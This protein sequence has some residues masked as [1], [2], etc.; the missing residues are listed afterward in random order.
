M[1][2][3]ANEED[4]ELDSSMMVPKPVGML[5]SPTTRIAAKFVDILFL[6]VLGRLLPVL[7]AAVLGVLYI[8]L[9]DGFQR[10]TWRSQSLGKKLFGI[11][12][13]SRISQEPAGFRESMI[14]NSPFGFAV[15]FGMI[16]IWGWI[17]LIFIGIPLI[18]IEIFLLF[19]VETR[20]RLG[21]VMADTEIRF[22]NQE[23]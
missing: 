8:M 2:D 14:R 10:G 12:V 22:V 7:L 3:G 21:D 11:R 17:L 9:A 23:E 16:A 18:L 6:F 13:Y 5:P 4:I 19:R 15:F 20:Q 1:N